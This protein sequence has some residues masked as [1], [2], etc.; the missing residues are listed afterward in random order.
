MVHDVLGHEHRVLGHEVTVS[1]NT[2]FM[3]PYCRLHPMK[4]GDETQPNR[5]EEGECTVTCS[6]ESGPLTHLLIRQSTSGLMRC[7]D[8]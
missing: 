6:R 1:V 2:R 7:P 4:S 8:D 5:V 3:T